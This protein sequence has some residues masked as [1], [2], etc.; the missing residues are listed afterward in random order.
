[1]ANTKKSALSNEK[2]LNF[3]P[4]YQDFVIELSP[5][6]LLQIMRS[7]QLKASDVVGNYAFDVQDL[8]ERM[9]AKFFEIENI[10]LKQLV[11]VITSWPKQMNWPQFNH[12][13]NK[14]LLAWLNDYKLGASL[15]AAL[16]LVG[17]LT[18]RIVKTSESH[19]LLNDETSQ[20]IPSSKFQQ[21]LMHLLARVTNQLDQY[22]F[23]HIQN[24][25]LETGLPNLQVMLNFL[26][27][28]LQTD[29][30]ETLIEP[31]YL[32]SK[33]TVPKHLGLILVNLNINF[34]ETSQLNS[35]S[36]SLMMAAIHVIKQ[37]L[38]DGT[39]LFR[40]GPVE[41][42]IVI[43][44]ISFPAQLNLIV[45]KIM[46][47]F[48]AELPLDNVTLIL[49]PYFGGV[50][51][52]KTRQNAIAMHDCARL[53]LHHAMI[54]NYHIE[55][56][57]QHITNAFSDAHQLDEAIIQALQQN[58]L[59]IF[60][61]PIISLPNEICSNAETLLRWKNE[62]WPSISPIRLVDTIYKKGFSKVFIR[63]LISNAC[64][65][66]AELKSVNERNISLTINLSGTDL[67]DADL[68]DLLAQSVALWEIPAENLIVEITESD[69]LLDEEKAMQ[70]IDKIVALGCKLAL[71]DFGT[72]YSSMTRLRSMPIDLVKID[73]SFVKNIATSNE[74]KAIV[75][76]VV[77]LAHSLGKAVVAEGVEDLACLNI[78]KKMECEKIQGYY[79]AKP[80][81]FAE[82]TTWL[83]LFEKKQVSLIN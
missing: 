69:L 42:G 5:S 62:K 45:S 66:I 78:L 6:L 40:I 56:Y 23:S 55:F 8:N 57:D 11:N 31:S 65:R 47:A 28:H 35:A 9:H 34:D 12:Q 76:S 25:D 79:Y 53:A 37:H 67:L 49:K 36:S 50:S 70:V 72:G 44:H 18:L 61:Q 39:T 3:T 21:L 10:Y 2:E 59:E 46:H 54:N 74:D 7:Y 43:Q 73:Q 17:C 30:Q 81:H 19:D 68:P 75:H 29:H 24:F 33:N 32:N 83:D 41:L 77:K 22:K 26:D 82:F 63:W 51:S 13:V 80:M 16:L 14:L 38:N 52:L 64:Q 60:L 4:L 58:E 27:Q 20:S 71:D 15:D 1:M 48:E